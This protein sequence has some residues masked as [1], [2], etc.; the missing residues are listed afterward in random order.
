MPTA[1]SR[2]FALTVGGRDSWQDRRLILF[3]AR[4][5]GINVTRSIGGSLNLRRALADYPLSE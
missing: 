4:E 3:Q 1:G 5:L 2:H